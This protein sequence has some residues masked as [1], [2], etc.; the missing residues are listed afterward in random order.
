MCEIVQ[1]QIGPWSVSAATHLLTLS[2]GEI[3][4]L[5]SLA[6]TW[7]KVFIAGG[8]YLETNHSAPS[9]VIRVDYTLQEGIVCPY[10]VEERPAGFGVL[11]AL[12][13]EPYGEIKSAFTSLGVGILV[14][15]KREA[16]GSD[17]FYQSGIPVWRE[18]EESK[19]S[20][21]YARVHRDEE[22]FF[23]LLG[24]SVST[25]DREGCKAYGSVMNLW[26]PVPEYS[27][28][29]SLWWAKLFEKSFA[30][31][32][33]QGSRFDGVLI[34][35]TEKKRGSVTKTKIHEAIERGEGA[36]IQPY[37]PH[38]EG[39]DFLPE[40]YGLFRRVYLVFDPKTQIYKTVGGVYMAVPD[41]RG[42][43][44]KSAITGALLL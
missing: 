29:D 14:S 34:W 13:P 18:G 19:A 21:L 41:V 26:S 31:K 24:Q 2:A 20:L 8:N 23:G 32:Y 36:Y 4:Q 42:H 44:T 10:E 6:S 15:K 30:L 40:G 25:I 16:L 1:K 22:A 5:E 43:G 35:T 7:R 17:D 28:R 37:H 11:E 38:E 27:L 9:L 3:R 33:K 39:Y 12:A